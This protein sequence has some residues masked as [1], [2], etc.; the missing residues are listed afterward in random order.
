MITTHWRASLAGL[1]AAVAV[2]AAP[3]KP[4]YVIDGRGQKLEGIELKVTSAGGDIELNVDGRV[5]LPFKAGG[6]K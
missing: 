6:Y 2:T 5:R 1:L 3:A 4:C